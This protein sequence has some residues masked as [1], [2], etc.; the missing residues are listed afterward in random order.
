MKGVYVAILFLVV[1]G[2]AFL[3]GQQ[4]QPP[5][6][7][8]IAELFTSEGCSSCPAAE[9]LMKEMEALTAKESTAVVGLAFHITYWDHLGWKDPY[10][11]QEYTNRQ[12][13]YG[14]LLSS[15]QYTP[16]MVM[17]GEFEFVGGNPFAFRKTL[18]QVS[19][20]PYDY[21]LEANATYLGNQVTINYSLNKKSK[22]ELLNI[23]V[24][25]TMVEN[26]VKNGEN[27]DRLLRHHNVVRNFQTINLEPRGRVQMEMGADSD[28]KNYEV[29]LYV[30]HRRNLEI[31]GATK[32]KLNPD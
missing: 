2:F 31:L 13:K 26:R 5:K 7:I 1:S 21:T 17:N 30:Q 20:K 9:A 16:Q 6:P 14:E 32:M 24:V 12:K 4:A 25:E 11:R 22:S 18:S 27:K 10:G 23:A 29:V 28:L 15:Q 3:P 19:G 8:V